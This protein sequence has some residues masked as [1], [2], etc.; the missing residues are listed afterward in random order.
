MSSRT[1][2]AL[3]RL[4]SYASRHRVTV[5]AATVTS[6]LKKLFDI[7]PEIL[8]G[9]AVDVVVSGSASFVSRF[10][11]VGVMPQLSLLAGITLAI[12]VAES[13]CQ[14][15]SSI[16]WRNLAQTLQHQLRLDAYRH[17]QHLDMAYFEDR[18]TGGFVAILNDD[19]NQLERFL[20]N[21]ANLLLQFLTSVIL[22]GGVFFYLAPLVAL[23]AILPIPVIVFWT[24]HFQGKAQPLY[25]EVREKAALLSSRLAGSISGIATIKSYTAEEL[26]S[27]QLER[28]SLEYCAANRRAIQVSS[29]FIPLI[30]MAVLAGFLSTLLVG[31]WMSTRG[32]LT[33]G[34]YSVLVFLTQ[35]LLWPFST[36]ADTFDLYQRAMASAARVLDLLEVPV[37]PP[38]RG[39]PLDPS[40]VRGAIDFQDVTFAYPGRQPALSHLDLKIPAGSTAAFV[41]TTGSGKSTLVKLLL[42][43]YEPGEGRILLDGAP[44]GELSARD[45]RACI[46]LVS[47]DVFLFHGT[48]RENIAYGSQAATLEDV[49]RAARMAE[50]HDFIEQLP[51]GYDTLVGER[52]Q[53]LSG[54]QRQRISIA[55]AIL[56]D[57]PIMILDEATS[58]VDNETEAAIQ[59]SLA[60]I[61]VGRTT[62]V[63]AHRLSTI[64]KA[65]RIFV[66]ENGSIA[67]SG[68]SEELLAQGGLYAALWRVQTGAIAESVPVS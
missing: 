4:L 31:G 19:V 21:G 30:R 8:I 64:R 9:M 14:F 16:L 18:T 40:Q 38:D 20:D 43:F 52:G 55:R 41:G 56:K 27:A 26:E 34:S 28:E 36:L 3:L 6:I 48:I 10:G 63:V 42:R 12:W 51:Q 37:H 65:D 54:G 1:R 67:E 23:V 61:V 49:I 35:R 15:A 22:I 32:V 60:R 50:S 7:A 62:L 39:R 46:G 11:L 68:A 66:L 53:K 5:L 44:I 25:G 47:Q 13:F 45:L 58:A 57:P 59:R 29:A 2:P 24:F 33:V 17:V